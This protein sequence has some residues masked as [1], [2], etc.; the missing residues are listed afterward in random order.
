VSSSTAKSEMEKPDENNQEIL[1]SD[2]EN[3][4]NAEEE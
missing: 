3:F 1:I 2:S 4:K